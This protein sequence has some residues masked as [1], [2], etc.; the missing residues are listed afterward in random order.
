M[1]PEPDVQTPRQLAPQTSEE[2]VTEELVVTASA[3]RSLRIKTTT[4]E[5]E[6]ITTLD[7]K[8]PV[9]EMSA[10]IQGKLNLVMAEAT[11]KPDIAPC[12]LFT[13]NFDSISGNEEI[14]FTLMSID[15]KSGG[16][17]ECLKK[18]NQFA[19]EGFTVEFD[20]VRVGDP[21]SQRQVKNSQFR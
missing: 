4:T 7:G 18:L 13:K 3:N 9:T 21:L 15:K 20:N 11:F 2:T 1:S 5:D 17:S 12:K 16:L 8:L 10:D 19:F 14:A 6:I